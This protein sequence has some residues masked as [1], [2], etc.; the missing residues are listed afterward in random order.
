MRIEPMIVAGIILLLGGLALG[1]WYSIA[2]GAVLYASNRIN[3]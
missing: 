3:K 2:V 1:N